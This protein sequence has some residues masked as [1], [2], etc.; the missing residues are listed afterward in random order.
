MP[1]SLALLYAAISGPDPLDPTTRG[2]S[3][4]DPFA[5]LRRGVR[6]LRLARMPAIARDGMRA[7]D[8][9]GM[10]AYVAPR[11]AGDAV[12]LLAALRRLP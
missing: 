6:G 9:G 5:T 4:A 12:A 11:R 8:V 1:E 7:Y 10:R 2:I 3:P